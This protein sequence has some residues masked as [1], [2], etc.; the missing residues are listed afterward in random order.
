MNRTD[1]MRLLEAELSYSEREMAVRDA[2]RAHFGASASGDGSR[3]WVYLADCYDD[4]A[5]AN[6]EQDV[7]QPDGSL[8]SSKI[9][10]V[11]YALVDG[12]VTLGDPVEVRKV[13]TYE[14]VDANP[15]SESADVE[16]VGDLVPLVEK[17]LR[18]DGTVPIRIIAPGW[19]SSGY[20][21][22]EVL[23][24][25]GPNVFKSNL[26]MHIDHPT[27]AE[28]A[29]RPERS[30]TT[31][32]GVLASDARWE[33]NGPAGPGLYADAK[34]FAEF[35]ERLPELA[36]HIGVSIRAV[37]KATHGE[38]EGKRGP[39]IQEITAAKSVDYV[40]IP[41]AGGQVLQLFEAARGRT[42]SQE[43]LAVNEQE[44]QAL[45]E[46]QAALEAEKARL[47]EELARARE[48]LILREA[49][50]Y[51]GEVL[52][53]IQMP[54]LTRNRLIESLAGRPVLK[55]GALDKDAFKTAI[56]EAAKA[57]LEYLASVS[58]GSPVR[59]MGA[60]AS[61]GDRPRLVEAYERSF[62]SQG[63]TPERARQLA[64]IAAR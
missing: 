64:E 22:A 54:D 6:V 5:I 55:E 12:A 44:A 49:R 43:V 14:P 38:A 9:Y 23:K 56:Q 7:P 50:D 15:A 2:L 57:E 24:R 27:P 13:I 58:G 26:H 53:G 18:R 1:L 33:D 35:A 36:P 10:R 17:G 29:Q 37:G 19:G 3:T 59:G 30:I 61:G 47:T 4:Y 8:S 63:E 51:V 31:L 42:N 20:Y 52:A 48:A 60:V 21:S 46:S 62:L 32:G 28:E 16:L 25:D 39:I 40:T 45:R 41:G 11:S 34:P